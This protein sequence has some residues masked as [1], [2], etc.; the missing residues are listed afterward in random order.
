VEEFAQVLHLKNVQTLALR[1]EEISKKPE[2][3]H[4]FDCVVSRAVAYL[5]QVLDWA[6][7]FVKKSGK[8]L[9]LKTPSDEEIRDGN[10]YLS[11]HHLSMQKIPYEL[12]DSSRLILEITH[13]N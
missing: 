7:P 13:L 12:H 4:Q 5:P 9:L 8:I 6:L 1:A 11:T 10:Y 3:A 2:Y